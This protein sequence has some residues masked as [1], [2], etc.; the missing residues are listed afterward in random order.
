[1]GFIGT[2][3]KSRFWW[4]KVVSAGGFKVLCA[5]DK[6]RTSRRKATVELGTVEGLGFRV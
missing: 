2:L 5:M 4:V 1:M 3:Q 6:H